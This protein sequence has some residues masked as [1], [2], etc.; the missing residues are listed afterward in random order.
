MSDLTK[1]VRWFH[2]KK[3]TAI[4]G[5]LLLAFAVALLSLG[6][7]LHFGFAPKPYQVGHVAATTITAPED[8]LVEDTKAT[9]KKRNQTAL[10]QPLVYDL[11]TE[12]Y[13]TLKTHIEN[14]FQ[15]LEKAEPEYLEDI[16]WQLSE[17]LN[18]EIS[19]YTI[20]IWRDESFQNMVLGRVLPWL[21]KYIS[22]G[23]V[24]DV[25]TLKGKKY[26]LIKRNPVNGQEETVKD[27]T[28]VKD[29]NSLRSDLTLF[30]K[31][32]VK[33]TLGVR[34]AVWALIN[35]A[36]SP[37]LKYA[38]DETSK[39]INNRVSALQPE[40]F[41]V[42]QGE[43]IVRKGEVITPLQ[44]Q[45]LKAMAKNV[46]NNFTLHKIMGFFTFGLLFL[47]CL[48]CFKKPEASRLRTFKDY[49]L[50]AF[51]LL[52]FGSLAKLLAFGINMF[53]SGYMGELLPYALPLA[54]AAGVL[55][56]FFPPLPGTVILFILIF[57][58]TKILGGGLNLFC[59]Y[60][61]SSVVQLVIIN[62]AKTR[63]EIF[64]SFFPLLLVL[65]LSFTGIFLLHP[66]GGSAF[67]TGI[68]YS[69]VNAVLSLLLLF[70]LT[71]V[72]EFT[73]GYS[74]T[75][76]LLELMSLDQKLLQDL[77][78]KAPGTHHH[79]LVLSNMVDAGARAIGA[80][81]VMVRVA[82]LYH[83]VGKLSK[84]QYFI[85]NQT[86]GENK[87][88]KLSPSMSAL[89]LIS[90]VK[91]GVEMAREHKLGLDIENL[92]QQHHGTMLISYFYHKALEQAKAKGAE[93]PREEDFC[94]P[95]PKPQTKEAGLLLLADAIEASSRTLADP[96]PARIRGHIESIVK[97]IFTAG[98]L[99][100]SAL[101][102]KDLHEITNVFYRIITGVFHYRIEYPDEK[103]TKQKTAEKKC[104]SS[105]SFSPP[106][107]EG[108]NEVKSTSYPE[109]DHTGQTW[110]K[111]EA[112]GTVLKFRK[113]HNDH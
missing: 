78:V 35:P 104:S 82:A 23:V 84:P 111:E 10:S 46:E 64:A 9:E 15:G 67:F 76:R 97:K 106:C 1:K 53:P 38:A 12:V 55:A 8:F 89:I 6:T 85:E 110:G 47:L 42:R 44:Q 60:L 91:Q 71:P 40:Y 4:Q 92:I 81:A 7:S 56:L 41:Q 108:K 34:K 73:M 29:L 86:N 98:Q 105:D 112:A 50:L 70:A 43:I 77:M 113:V 18:T 39:R 74:S 24:K 65:L 61:F 45:K 79:S 88:D 51:I 62:E 107:Q 83:D 75:M 14:I 63:R 58:S 102:L 31:K 5:A 103:E 59:F 25:K 95:G 54:G 36:L 21:Q 20:K 52:C 28:K 19:L 13:T 26:G 100:E 2:T 27:I 80:N 99:D 94:Y 16:R 3:M 33:K 90:H 68:L 48:C 72:I 11:D 30:L 37:G 109:Q 69:V 93:I 49:L 22:Q 87:H 57:F 17:D 101:T 32:E 66:Q 96:T